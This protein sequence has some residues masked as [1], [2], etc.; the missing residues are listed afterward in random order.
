MNQKKGFIKRKTR[1]ELENRD[2]KN[3]SGGKR[4][5]KLIVVNVKY[6]CFKKIEEYSLNL[7]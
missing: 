4:E 3:K 2:V 1:R 6:I 7:Y 5:L